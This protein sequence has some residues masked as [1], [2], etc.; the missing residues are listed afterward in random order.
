MVRILLFALALA[1]CACTRQVDYQRPTFRDDRFANDRS[2]CWR[3][4]EQRAADQFDRDMSG[5]GQDNFGSFGRSALSNDLNRMDA[6]RFRSQVYEDCLRLR[7]VPAGD[8]GPVEEDDEAADNT[9]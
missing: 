8:P 3:Q 7:G 2:F 6:R 9:Q 1:L 4:A 5:P